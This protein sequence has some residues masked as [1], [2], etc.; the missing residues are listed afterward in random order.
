MDWNNLLSKKVSSIPSSGIRSFFDLVVGRKDIIS[1]GVGEPDFVTPWHIREA[2]I[3]S[4]KKGHTTY[5]SNMGL[6]SLRQAIATYCSNFFKLDY[7]P[8]DEILPTVG[9]SEAIDLALRVLLN[10]G[11]EVIYHEPSYVSYAP[12]ILLADGVPVIVE[13]SIEDC[14][15][16]NPAKLE[17]VITPRSKVLILNFPTNPTGAIAPNETLRAIAKICIRH[18]L[19]VLTDEIY[20]ELRYD[21][22]EHLCIATLPGMQE[23]TLLLHGF[24]KAFAMTGFRLGY[25]C[26]PKEII[27]QM[28]KIHSYS[29]ICPSITSQEAGIEALING[30]PAMLEMRDSYHMRRDYF[31]NRLN[32]MGMDCHLPGGAFYAFPSIKRFGLSSSDFALGLL[33]KYKVAAIPG[34]AF[35][36]CGEGY[37][38]CCYASSLTQLER[39]CDLMEQYCNSLLSEKNSET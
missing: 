26:G 34:T 2:A 25:A 35:G 19:I 29:M 17:A 27:E 13:T 4:L 22:I 18:N 7:S 31:V 36:A 10:K 5:T 30:T 23:R 1:L 33:K 11:D 37:L 6:E 20:S 39:A 12:S 38:R 21:G 8:I 32:Q 24:S 3:F 28:C 9:V 15:S 14:F 16:L